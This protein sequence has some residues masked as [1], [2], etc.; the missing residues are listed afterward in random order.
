MALT[1][2]A[3]IITDEANSYVQD[4]LPTFTSHVLAL[5]RSNNATVRANAA[6]ALSTLKCRSF[7]IVLMS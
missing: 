2:L 5:L 7:N 4:N 1:I 6:W 3:A